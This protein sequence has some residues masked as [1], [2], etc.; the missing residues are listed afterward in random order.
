[1]KLRW[2]I[3]CGRVANRIGWPLL[4]RPSDYTSQT[5]VYVSVRRSDLFTEVTVNGIR[6]FFRR[7][8]G[9]IDGVGFT[10]SAD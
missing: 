3:A 10:P 1:M 9:K 7:L 8:T 2:L 5:G 6:V 4:I